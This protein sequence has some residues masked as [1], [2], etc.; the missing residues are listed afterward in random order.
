MVAI[1]AAIN[2]NSYPALALTRNGGVVNT[3][4]PSNQFNHCIVCVP[5]EKDTVWLECTAAYDEMGELGYNIEDI[6]TLVIDGQNGKMVKTPIKKSYQNKW[7]SNTKAALLLG[8]LSFTTEITVEGNQKDYL[9]YNLAKSNSKDDVLFLTDLLNE[10]YSNLNIK[11]Y[12][13]SDQNIDSID[14]TI[15]LEGTYNK[16]LPVD[17]TRL[18]FNPAIFNRKAADDLPKETIGKRSY[19]VYFSYPY[20]NVDTVKIAMPRNYTLEAK[21]SDQLIDNDLISYKTVFD[22]RDGSLFYVRSFELKK[23]YI[24]LNE[25][26]LFYETVKKIIEMDKAKF[27]LKKN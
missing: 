16:F 19:P 12:N 18:F 24:P 2:I 7:I 14:Y 10:N 8:D 4:Y 27:V 17:G 13:L 5:L 20:L 23:N 1:L 11:M 15:T 6:Y 22:L 3:M 21:P 25:Y 9:R 26:P